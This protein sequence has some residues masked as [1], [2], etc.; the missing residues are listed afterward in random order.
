MPGELEFLSDHHWDCIT[1]AEYWAGRRKQ[2]ARLP[3]VRAR[4]IQAEMGILEPPKAK[5]D[6]IAPMT[7]PPVKPLIRKPGTRIRPVQDTKEL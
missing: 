6:P 4:G 5:V 7:K 3:V 1:I 2:E